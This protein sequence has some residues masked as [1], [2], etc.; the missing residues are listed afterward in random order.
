MG[1]T[2]FFHLGYVFQGLLSV[3]RCK[4][5]GWKMEPVR[6]TYLGVNTRNVSWSHGKE[7]NSR[8]GMCIG[9][10]CGFWHELTLLLLSGKSSLKGDIL[11]KGSSLVTKPK[12]RA[13]SGWS[14]TVAA[15]AAQTFDTP[16]CRLQVQYL[17]W[18]IAILRCQALLGS[19][20][21]QNSLS[22][23]TLM[24]GIWRGRQ[25][26]HSWFITL[27]EAPKFFQT[28]CATDFLSNDY[29]LNF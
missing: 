20:W 22:T 27:P 4:V 29:L 10:A 25:S 18:A 5:R 26:H 17:L 1:E 21:L 3:W 16:Q 2:A 23:S 9:V 8:N 14:L 15:H 19:L 7:E 28:M 13:E 24:V 12:T 11:L 6:K